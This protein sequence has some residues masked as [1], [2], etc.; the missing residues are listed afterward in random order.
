MNNSY[1]VSSIRTRV[2]LALLVAGLL[3]V[4][5]IFIFS[6]IMLRQSILTSEYDR[7]RLLSD[8]LTAQVE[9]R[10]MDVTEQFRDLLNNEEFVAF[11]DSAHVYS[12]SRELSRMLADYVAIYVYDTEGHLLHATSYD[13]YISIEF[14]DWISDVMQGKIVL[15]G[16]HRDPDTGL[17]YLTVAGAYSGDHEDAERIVTAKIPFDEI[18][19]PLKRVNMG[20]RSQVV[21]L[22]KY[23]TIL[24]HPRTELLLTA[25]HADISPYAWLEHPEGRYYTE[26]G[27]TFFYKSQLVKAH[28]MN[29]GKTWCLL[30]TRPEN[31]V[32]YLSQ[33]EAHIHLVVFAVALLVIMLI[34]PVVESYFVSITYSCLKCCARGCRRRF[35]NPNSS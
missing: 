33:Q 25:F 12:Q 32:Y 26:S 3:P 16:P 6:Q 28:Q 19:S 1:N 31:E 5:V 21:L 35:D 22:N 23:G 29:V 10:L 34:G 4:I 17:L 11:I 27:E 24:Y 8:Q 30:I 20:A 18:M 15:S 9:D 7:M 13:Q 14:A 2:L